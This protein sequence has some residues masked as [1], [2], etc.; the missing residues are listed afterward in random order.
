MHIAVSKGRLSQSGAEV[1]VVPVLSGKSLAGIPV[2]GNDAL[3]RAERLAK[4]QDFTGKAGEVLSLPAPEGHGADVLLCIGVGEKRS[5]SF[6]DAV[7]D[8]G[9]NAVQVAKKMGLRT[10]AADFSAKEMMHADAVEAFVT[11]ILLTNYAFDAYK[12]QNGAKRV[13]EVDILLPDSRMTLV[14]RKTI[15]RVQGVMAGVNIARDLVN[16]PAHD[17]T[18]ERLA[19]AA[20]EIAKESGGTIKVK[21]LE[22]AECQKLGMGAYLAVAQG[23]DRDPKFIT[24]SYTS[25]RPAKKNVAVIG[26][27]VTFDSGGLSIKPADSMMTMKCDMAGAAAVIGLFAVLGKLRPRVNIRGYIA[28]T[29]N[30]PSGNAVRPGDVV[31]SMSGKTIEVLNTDA[32]GRLTLADALTY[33]L[34]EKPDMMVDL[35]TLTGACMVGLGE[36]IAGLMSN[37]RGLAKDVLKSAKDAGEKLWEMPLEPRYQQLIQS[38]IAD[39]R[40]I[41][42]SRYGGSLTAGLFLQEFVEET[43]WAHLDIAGPA[44]AERPM[45][46]C[47]QKG[48]TGYGVRTLWKWVEGMGK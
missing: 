44:F 23:A 36:E 41:A 34:R 42:T 32:E 3:R 33:A 1:L 46:V 7:R 30:M 43:P 15:E 45:G 14:L 8:M 48:A 29:E 9:G 13:A 24:L 35:A 10:I 17:M 12:K 47:L 5:A 37:D 2:L 38:D 18:P 4:A 22:R 6:L 16:I 11:G 19:E 40:N 21:V 31:R 25:P 20:Q 28:A 39:L 27:G 26:K